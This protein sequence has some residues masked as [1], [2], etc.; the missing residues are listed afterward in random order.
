MYFFTLWLKLKAFKLLEPHYNCKN[1]GLM[2]WNVKLLIGEICKWEMRY[3]SLQRERG[4]T[5]WYWFS[6]VFWLHTWQ[7]GAKAF[8]GV[9]LFVTID[10]WF[11]ICMIYY[12]TSGGDLS[13]L[14]C[15]WCGDSVWDICMYLVDFYLFVVYTCIFG[16]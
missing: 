14:L 12:I 10:F 3:Q 13:N 9:L 16:L 15:W 1:M 8:T 7:K 4:E 5:K 2:H 6:T 11:H